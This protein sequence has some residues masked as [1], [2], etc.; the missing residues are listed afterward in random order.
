MTSDQIQEIYAKDDDSLIHFLWLEIAFRVAYIDIVPE[1]AS[2]NEQIYTN[3]LVN[4]Y[5]QIDG[6]NVSPTGTIKWELILDL[7]TT[8]TEQKVTSEHIF[9]FESL[10]QHEWTI[11]RNFRGN[12]STND[13][14][15][16]KD[17]LTLYR[18]ILLN[19]PLQM[20][21]IQKH[22][23]RWSS[24]VTMD[25]SD[26]V[27]TTPITTNIIR[28]RKVR[29]TLTFDIEDGEK[30]MKRY[31]VKSY[32]RR[33][34]IKGS[35]R[36]QRRKIMIWKRMQPNV[37]SF[38]FLVRKEIPTYPK[39]HY[40]TSDSDRVNMER[41]PIEIREQIQRYEEESEPVPHSPTLVESLCTMWPEL[42]YLRGLF[43]VAQSNLR[44]TIILPSLIIAKNIGRILLF[45]GSEFPKDWEQMRREVHIK[46]TPDGTEYSEIEFPDKWKRN[47][48]QIKLLFPFC[49]KPWHSHSPE[50]Q[51]EKK[52][53]WSYL[54]TLRF[55]T[56]IPFGDPIP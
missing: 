23:P 12:V 32:Y 39:D 24:N 52:L 41:I 51:F 11:L 10:G 27:D 54:T 6:R 40:D 47:G 45:Q 20:K 1:I 21:E 13:S 50:L 2:C 8:N 46:C 17:F 16:T 37:H 29:S 49:L 35:I 22:V 5:N 53:R 30:V 25:E 19:E 34:L 7:F 38:F 36:S 15:Q 48:M 4:I 14:M 56:D 9:L 44:K 55:E 3:Y 31:F 26:D 43:L 42:N 18:E 28:E 33:N